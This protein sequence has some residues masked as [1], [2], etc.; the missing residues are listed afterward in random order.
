MTDLDS[1]RRHV[2]VVDDDPMMRAFLR[3]YLDE[4]Y[5]VDALS[6]G[7]EA[8]VRL[9]EGRPLDVLI[10]DLAMER[11]GGFEVLE[12]VRARPDLDGLPVIVLS[13]TD[14]SD[15]RVRCLEAGADDFLVKPFNPRELLARV[16]NLLRRLT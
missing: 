12:H 3:K 8:L 6:D 7:D 4:D 1:T 2:L 5:S 14:A 9:D 11:V 15:E 10:L 13:G 16:K